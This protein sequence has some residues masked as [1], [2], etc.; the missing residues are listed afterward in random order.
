MYPSS[1]TDEFGRGVGVVRYASPF[2]TV[3]GSYSPTSHKHALRWY[4]YYFR[5]NPIINPIITNLSEYPITAI[6]INEDSDE[7]KNKWLNILENILQIRVFQ[8]KMGLD[9]NTYG[10]C[11]AYIHF[12]IMKYLVCQHCKHSEDVKDCKYQWRNMCFRLECKKCKMTTENAE[13]LDY[14]EKRWNGIKLM[15]YNPELIDIDYNEITGDKDYFLTLPNHFKNDIKIGKK[16]IIENIPM[17]YID[18]VK[19]DKKLKLVNHKIFAFERPTISNSDHGWGGSIIA[20]VLGFAFQLQI[21]LKAQEAILNDYILPLRIIYPQAGEANG[22]PITQMGLARFSALMTRELEKHRLDPNHKIISSIPVGSELVGAEGKSL[23]L[24]QELETQANLI[25]NGMNV[26]LELWKG[27][28]SWSG[29]NVSLK[30]LENKFLMYR[31]QMLQMCKDFILK[32]ICEHM[33]MTP[34]KIGFAEFRMADDLQASALQFQLYQSQLL[35]GQT[36]L[37]SMG[38]DWNTESANMEKELSRN[39]SRQRKLNLATTDIQGQAQLIQTNYAVQAQKKQMLAG[40]PGTPVGTGEQNNPLAALESNL[41]GAIG[42]DPNQVASRIAGEM[43]N[44]SPEQ[45]ELINMQLQGSPD[46]MRAVNNEKIKSM[47]TQ[48]DP[49]SALQ[50]PLPESKPPRRENNVTG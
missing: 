3:G 47:G 45:Q 42:V 27:G 10:I 18:A 8:I 4:S 46:L 24:Y 43:E 13:Q 31:K 36:L 16:H 35:S 12:P 48:S 38:K 11:L 14:A 29:S 6:E 49:L 37:K 1:S 32:N 26:P 33:G 44:A 15:R 41:S 9:Y 21:L 5:T 19:Q 23:T 30:F 39:L 22:S 25:C 40:A 7:E 17:E 20:P 28:L 34:P 50:S 2:N